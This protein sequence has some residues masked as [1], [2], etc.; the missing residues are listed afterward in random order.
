MT[1]RRLL[2]G[3]SPTYGGWC[4]IA[5]PLTAELMGRTG[6][7]WV[8]VDSQHGSIDQQTT[9][10]MLQALDAARVPGVVRVPW[11]EPAGIM[12]ALDA[13]AQG[14]IVPM[15][16]TP[17]EAEIA[18]RSCRYPPAGFRSWGLSRRALDG[19]EYTAASANAETVC[20]IQIETL[21][22][23]SRAADIL[24]VPGVDVVYV[25]PAD[26]AVSAG[27]PPTFTVTDPR[28]EE[29]ILDLLGHCLA[30]DV[31]PGIHSPDPGT[32]GRW[33]D[34]GFRFITVT[35]DVGCIRRQAHETVAALRD[36][37]TAG[38]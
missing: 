26:L 22:G 1:L 36:A 5:S 25:G 38:A 27:I 11:N 37:V 28:H 18:V 8:C 33:R 7:D 21:N 4:S 17:E 31:V 35:S 34:A 12:K 32:A 29:L 9:V 15:V 13:G 16:N 10:A 30:R 3:R 19:R 24:S 23:L 14:V 6:V 20:A 2:Q